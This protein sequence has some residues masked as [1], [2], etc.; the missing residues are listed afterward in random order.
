MADIIKP[1][2]NDGP[3]NAEAGHVTSVKQRDPR[4]TAIDSS[5]SD[6]LACDAE[7]YVGRETFVQAHLRIQT[8]LA[9]ER[10]MKSAHPRFCDWSCWH[11]WASQ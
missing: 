5:V 10:K 7:I 1:D 9:N 6:C 3:P 2:L 8:Q 4:P 11:E